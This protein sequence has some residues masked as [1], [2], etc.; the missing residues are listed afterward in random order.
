M[1]ANILLGPAGSGKTHACLRQIAEMLKAAPDGTPLLLLA[2]RQSTYLLERQLLALSVAGFTRLQIFSFDRIAREILDQLGQPVRDVL[3]E[4][5]RV[6]VLRALLLQCE[7][8]LA[9]FRAS[10]RGAGFAAQLSQILRELQ[11]GGVTPNSLRAVKLSEKSSGTLAGKLHDI[12]LLLE[13]YRAWLKA[14][15]LHDPDDLLVRAAEELS[16]AHKTSQPAPAYAGLWLDGFAEMTQPEINLLCALLPGCDSATLAFCLEN[17]ASESNSSSLWNVTATTL[18]RCRT[19][20]EQLG[21]SCKTSLLPGNDGL[22]RFKSAPALNQLAAS[23]TTSQSAAGNLDG[24]NFVE[25]SDPEA[26]AL[27]ATR[28]ISDHVHKCHGRYRDISVIVRRMDDYADV[29]Q[30]VFRRHGIPFFADHREPMGHHPVAELTRSA[31][32]L[33]ARGWLHEDWIAALKTGLVA[34]NTTLIDAVE[35]AALASGVRGSEWLDLPEYQRKID[36]SDDA[37]NCLNKPIAAFKNFKT[38]TADEISGQQL[39][40]FI[41]KFWSELAVPDALEKWQDETEKLELPPIYR[42][43]HRTAWE[44]INAWCDNLALAFG[45]TKLAARDWLAIAEAGLSGL[46]LGVIPPAL[47][48]VFVGAVDRARQPEVKLAIILGLNESVFPAA[49]AAPV[50]LNRAERLALLSETDLD[51]AWNPVQLAS[52]ENYYAYIACTRPGEKLC[53]AW[54]RRGRDGKTLV[55]SSVAERLLAFAG[56]KPHADAVEADVTH[57]DGTLKKFS[58]N[59]SPTTATSLPELFECANWNQSLPGNIAANHPAQIA[60]TDAARWR[61]QLATDAGG[62]SL[63]LGAAAL[64]KLFPEH[65][66]FSSVS[67]LEEFAECPFRHFAGRQ[68]HLQKRDE[69]VADAASSGTLLHAILKRFHEFTLAEKLRWRNW[70]AADAAQKIRSLGAELLA[71]D[72]FA[73][74]AQDDLVLWESRRKIERLAEAIAQTI[75]WL[76]TCAFDPVL[77]EFKFGDGATSD[78]AAWKIALG[79]GVSLKLQGSIDRVDICALP[80]GRALVAV[81]DYK[82]WLK[83]PDEARMQNGLELQLLGYLAFAV[84]SPELKNKISENLLPAGAFYVPLQ[85]KVERSSLGDMADDRE[86]K[87]LESLAHHG[88]ADRQWL[89]QF[90]SSATKTGGSWD[91]SGQFKFSSQSKNFLDAGA[92]QELLERNTEF[93]KQHARKILGGEVAVSPARSG[94]GKTACDFCVFRPFCRFDPVFGKFR[95]IAKAKD[96]SE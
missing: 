39:A 12:A 94:A 37:V 1:T 44:Q 16:H 48:Q 50:L 90:D 38:A 91:S 49:P 27:L 71:S 63:R 46:T 86:K 67:A 9:A 88:R 64:Q 22:P 8:Q 85:P 60:A 2:P 93:L 92:F 25:C 33:A 52:R 20:I 70:N 18:L 10:A 30:R 77:S 59:L 69:F 55:R 57:F 56:L 65:T 19:Q 28:L 35:N 45:E 5:G 54:S 21:L 32:R 15:A 74:Q 14:H 24:L 53:G 47:D 36:L 4:E 7:N 17:S 40:Q 13:S 62:K 73:A 6:M 83:K 81:F 76:G 29:L 82:S 11:R 3:F 51:L 41:R 23:W 75:R 42:A 34:D 61:E 26:E 58:G 79:D 84:E 95:V 68:L 96:N 89:E 66:L 43:I 78:A 31:L 87:S 72:D 80:D